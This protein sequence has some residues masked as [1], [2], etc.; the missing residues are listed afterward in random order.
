MDSKRQTVSFLRR[1][2]DRIGFRPQSRLGQNFL[3]D[4]NLLD[5]IVRTADLRPTDVV[6]EVG[7]GTGSLTTRLAEHA[8]AVVSVELD[9]RSAALA[10]DQLRSADNVTLLQQDALRNKNHLHSTVVT[11]VQKQLERRDDADLKLVANLPYSVATPVISNLLAS[12]IVP[13]MMIVTIQ[14]ELADRI[15]ASPRT[16][17]YGSFSVWVQSQC[18]VA[19]VRELHPS[20]FWPRPQVHSVILQLVL[21][22]AKRTAIGDPVRFQRFVRGLFLHRRK[23]LRGALTGAFKELAKSDVD[24]LMQQLKLGPETR[25]E[26]LDV[27]QIL[28]LATAFENRSTRDRSVDPAS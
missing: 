28:E 8:A 24:Q 20:V 13:S 17:D 23:F 5:L 6:L 10:A 27:P 9:A 25:A 2:F 19:I 15:V 22:P 12:Q 18:D 14:K 4:L 11:E 21:V 1:R 3:I 26:E 7:A 16:K